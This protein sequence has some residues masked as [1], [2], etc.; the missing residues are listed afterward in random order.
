MTAHRKQ[1]NRLVIP[2]GVHVQ[3]HELATARALANE[4][5]T[6]T[7][8]RK[9]TKPREHSADIYIDGVAWEMK[10]PISPKKKAIEKNLREATEQSSHIIFDARRMKRLPD[11]AI[12]QEVRVCAHKRIRKIERLIYVNKHGNVINIK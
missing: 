8:I 7:F 4:G 11:H 9:S 12:E 5:Y 3:P 10:S 6:V 2:T 1:K